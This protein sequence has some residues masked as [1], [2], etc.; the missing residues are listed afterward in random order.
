MQKRGGLKI[1]CRKILS[2]S[3][4][5][6]RGRTVRCFRKIRESRNFMHKGGSYDS[7]SKNLCVKVPK[8]FVEKP[9]CFGKFLVSKNFMDKTGDGGGSITIFR[10]KVSHSTEKLSR[11]TLL[12]FRKFQGS[13]NFMDKRGGGWGGQLLRFSVENFRVSKNVRDERG[14]LSRFSVKIVLSQYR[15]IS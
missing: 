3:A 10:R 14:R 1:Y 9:L 5:K 8:D 2:H 4:E 11:G 15:I 7:P 6:F 12:C 13:K